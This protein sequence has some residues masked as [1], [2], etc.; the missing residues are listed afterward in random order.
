L[1]NLCRAIGLRIFIAH[2]PSDPLQQF[3]YQAVACCIGP[4][5]WHKSCWTYMVYLLFVTRRLA[6]FPRSLVYLS[7]YA[8]IDCGRWS[9]CKVKR[10]K[11]LCTFPSLLQWDD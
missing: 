8:G 3:S 9:A 6:I 5:C 4:I 2:H 11:A 10:K 1:S 7:F